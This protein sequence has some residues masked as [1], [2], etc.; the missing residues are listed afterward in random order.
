MEVQELFLSQLNQRISETSGVNID[1]ELTNMMKLQNAYS[2]AARV[3]DTVNQM[4]EIL[5]SMGR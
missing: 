3:I 4:F 5:E 1:E 2:A